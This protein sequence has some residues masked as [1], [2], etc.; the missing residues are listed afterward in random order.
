MIGMYFTRKQDNEFYEAVSEP[1]ND[2][3]GDLCLLSRKVSTKQ[4]VTIELYEV[5][6]IYTK[7]EYYELQKV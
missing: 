1:V 6:K 4:S 7:E 2:S 3:D 5:D